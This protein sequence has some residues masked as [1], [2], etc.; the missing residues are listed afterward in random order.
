MIR[1]QSQLLGKDIV[2]E[3]GRGDPRGRRGPDEQLRR[4]ICTGGGEYARS[5]D[6]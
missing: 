6:S 4:R 1:R 5:E 2:E 3:G